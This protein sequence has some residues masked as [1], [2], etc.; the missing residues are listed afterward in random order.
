MRAGQ[1]KTYKRGRRTYALENSFNRGMRYS[2]NPIL[3]GEHRALVNFDFSADRTTLTPRKALIEQPAFYGIPD[4][5]GAPP[6]HCN[7]LIDYSV[8]AK[9]I[10]LIAGKVPTISY[11]KVS[12]PSNFETGAQFNSNNNTPIHRTSIHK[13]PYEVEDQTSPLGTIAYDSDFY[14]FNRNDEYCKFAVDVPSEILV[15]PRELSASEAAKYGYNMLLENPYAFKDVLID[16]TT[17]RIIMQG[18]LPYAPD[19]DELTFDPRINSLVRYRAFYTA[20]KGK[21]MVL[22]QIR[23]VES[24][25]WEMVQAEIVDLQTDAEPLTCDIRSTGKTLLVRCLVYPY[26]DRPAAVTDAVDGYLYPNEHGTA[27]KVDFLDTARNIL[28]S[29]DILDVPA[30]IPAFQ[31]IQSGFNFSDDTQ[32]SMRGF[33]NKNYDLTTCRGMC[34][35]NKSIVFYAPSDA[36]NTLFVS[37]YQEPEYVPYPNNCDVFDEDI[38]YCVPY[39]SDL[40]VFTETRLFRLTLNPQGGWVKTEVQGNLNIMPEDYSFVQVVKNM[41]YFKSGDAYYM[42]V[43]KAKTQGELTLAPIS[44]SLDELFQNF[45]EG[46]KDILRGMYGVETIPVTAKLRCY[47]AYSYLDYED[48]HNVYRLLITNEGKKISDITVEI[49][50]NSVVRNW[51]IHTYQTDLALFPY[52][53]DATKETGLIGLRSDYYKLIDR[54]AQNDTRDVLSYADINNLRLPNHPLLDTGHHDYNIETSKRLRELQFYISNTS[55][56]DL[57]FNLEYILDEATRIP[58]Y[59]Y[60]ATAVPTSNPNINELVLVPKDTVKMNVPNYTQLNSWKLGRSRFPTV[61]LWKIRTNIS[62]RGYAPRF[63]LMCKSG[64]RFEILNYTWVFRQLYLR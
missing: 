29:M 53:A 51:R 37:A 10:R 36:P 61:K 59:T 8:G 47:D 7:R 6:A 58:M 34:Y 9:Y 42:I 20:N 18:I 56:E 33:V 57:I 39:L 30:R 1:Y 4:L 21:Y 52:T 44:R 22:W 23:G 26:K 43:P 55:L 38:M 15:A 63:R 28:D 54:V 12:S 11:S 62:G 31:A 27:T 5:G 45:E 40:L 17:P 46:I 3:E 13:I 48:I 14:T 50:Y 41:V 24:A 32:L 16:E 25:N 19:T 49:L 35:W 60:T 64:K 2:D